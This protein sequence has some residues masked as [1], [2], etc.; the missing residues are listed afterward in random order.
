MGI[1]LN[2]IQDFFVTLGLD[3]R[4]WLRGIREADQAAGKFVASVG[5]YSGQLAT[6]TGRFL[7]AAGTEASK[8]GTR[9]SAA[10]ES[11][12][13]SGA[14]MGKEL[15]STFLTLGKT[16]AGVGA[17]TYGLFKLVEA[18]EKAG[19]VS[20]S[21]ERLSSSMGDSSVVLDEMRRA[22]GGAVD[23]QTLMLSA[24]KLLIADLGLSKDQMAKL[25]AAAVTMSH[26]MGTT[27]ASAMADLAKG[28][29]RQSPMILDNLGIIVKEE[30]ALN[31]YAKAN[32]VA[33][34]ALDERTKKIIFLNA[35]MEALDVATQNLGASQ[36]ASATTAE[37]LSTMWQNLLDQFVQVIGKSPEVQ[38]A[39]MTIATAA[40]D[41][42]KSALLGLTEWIKGLGGV[43]A[44]HFRLLAVFEHVKVGVHS[45]IF[46]AKGFVLGVSALASGIYGI[47]MT[48][49]NVMKGVANF[50]AGVFMKTL[51]GVATGISYVLAGIAKIPG[52]GGGAVEQLSKDIG[53]WADGAHADSKDYF[54]YMNESFNDIGT[55][56]ENV[57]T[58]IQT[59]FDQLNFDNTF[60]EIYTAANTANSLWAQAAES[61]ERFAA[62][63]GASSRDFLPV[64]GGSGGFRQTDA[65]RFTTI[66][67]SPG[68]A[69]GGMV[70]GPGGTDRVHARLTA[71]EFVVRR[72]AAQRNISFLSD[73][74]AGR[75]GS[76]SAP[77]ALG[78][79]GTM[80]NQKN[81]LHFH[82]S[83]MKPEQVVGE[84]NRLSRQG[85]RVS[86]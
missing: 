63:P 8:M 44:S 15:K 18:G 36:D 59:T 35:T 42:G 76:T 65:E 43:E 86:K 78:G 56:W 81:E 48:V 54:D 6:E 72:E 49:W 4:P 14:D 26:A 53:A 67:Y 83:R 37:K 80:F 24:N 23:D 46:L 29:A 33:V 22:T 13:K 5:K 70:T 17:A 16:I 2:D 12:K 66:P 31:K 60:D 73:M 21:F 19:N 77:P 34:E 28:I 41:M 69:T 51:A 11:I 57:G 3:S 75:R 1:S 25:G 71:G 52:M 68:F 38:D 9:M 61:A 20:S 82:D 62:G 74:N 55:V 79:G 47:F 32:G 40:Y 45:I 10:F 58:S 30:E 85:R 64:G 7:G 39:F 84:L 50:W 27:A